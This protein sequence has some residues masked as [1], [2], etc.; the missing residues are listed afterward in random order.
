MKIFLATSFSGKVDYETKEVLP[1][2][3]TFVEQVLACLRKQSGIEVFCAVEQEGW[4]ITDTPPA[5]TVQDDLEQVDKAD[6][7]LALV[8]EEPS[9]GV[10]FEI[11]YAT[12]KGKRVILLTQ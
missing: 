11:G 2:F 6:V 4:I 1:E 9:A 12:A 5:I 10:Q 8:D 3:K 7:L